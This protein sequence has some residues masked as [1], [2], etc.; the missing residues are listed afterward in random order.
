MIR[1][2]ATDPITVL[3]ADDHSLVRRGFRRILEDDPA[4]QSS[5]KPERRR[6]DPARR[7]AKPHVIVMDCAMPGTNGLI[8]TTQILARPGVAVLM[9]S[10]HAEDTLV[11]QAL[12]G[13]ARGYILKNALDLDLARRSSVCR[14]GDRLDPA[15]RRRGAERR[16]EPRPHARELEVLQLIC[17][18]LSNRDDR[19]KLDAEREHGRRAPREHHER[20]RRPQD[21][22]TR[23][24]R[25]SARVGQ[26][27]VNRRD[28]LATAGA[29]WHSRALGWPTLG[30]P[31]SA[32]ASRRPRH[33]G[34]RLVD[35]TAAVGPAVPPQQ[36]RLRRQAAAGNTRLGLRVPRLRRRRLAGHP[37]RERQDWPGHKRQR[38]TLRC[39]ATTATAHSPT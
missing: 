27:A 16:T 15:C 39:I 11:R 17:E 37:A 36:R 14:R 34:F 18:G 7:A 2:R 4:S 12:G 5:A 31:S 8:A 25:D 1:T 26:A 9:L 35:V 21:G 30:P 10:M 20:A 22:R 29:G 38:S 19:D 3:L 32:R 33:R 13:G 24:L 28:F 6:S 23:R